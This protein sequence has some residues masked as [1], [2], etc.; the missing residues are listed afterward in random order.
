MSQ[1]III[2]GVQQAYLD[3]LRQFDHN[4]SEDP[5]RNRKFIGILYEIDGHAYFAPLSS[6]K[7]KHAKIPDHAPDIFKLK[8]GELGV[9][10]LNNMIPA[11]ESAIINIDISQMSDQKY[12]KLLREQMDFIRKYAD[13]IRKKAQRLY[14]I[15]TSGHR[16]TLNERCCQYKL[17]EQMAGQFGLVASTTVKEIATD[18]LATDEYNK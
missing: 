7:P 9:I 15:V 3:Y 13:T 12:Q 17:L 6:P 14:R 11:A 2:C 10:N 16:P 1:P 18:R 8:N 4:V 5:K